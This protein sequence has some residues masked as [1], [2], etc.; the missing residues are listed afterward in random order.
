MHSD[1][2]MRPW[3]LAIGFFCLLGAGHLWVSGDL[4]TRASLKSSVDARAIHDVQNQPHRIGFL[5]SKDPALLKAVAWS[6]HGSVLYPG[7]GNYLPTRFDLSVEELDALTRL[8]SED[9][10]ASWSNYDR[11][12]KQLLYC[13]PA[14]RICLIYDRSEL[15]SALHV[16]LNGVSRGMAGVLVVMGLLSLFVVWR[17]GTAAKSNDRLILLPEQHAARRGALEVALTPRDFRLLEFLQRRQG[18]VVT[19]D[20]LYDAGWGRNFMPNSRALDQHII[21]LRKKLDPDK[22]RSPVIETVRGVGYKLLE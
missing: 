2:M 18:E 20:E 8:T 5:L 6:Q 13:Q 15:Q 7:P 16:S 1:A 22:S 9:F 14:P 11:N 12:G 17:R 10:Q 4:W 3:L 21:N 19:K